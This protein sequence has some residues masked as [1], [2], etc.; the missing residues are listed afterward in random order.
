MWCSTVFNTYSIWAK[1]EKPGATVNFTV[2][3]YSY[4]EYK[5]IR[6]ATLSTVWQ[7]FTMQFTVSGSQTYIRAP[8]HFCCQR[9]S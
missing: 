1:A 2:G 5:A 6:P 9:T 3:N 4:S 8:V 7:K